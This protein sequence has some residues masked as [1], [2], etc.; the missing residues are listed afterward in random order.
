MKAKAVRVNSVTANTIAKVNT[1]LFFFFI[2]LEVDI[3]RYKKNS[4]LLPI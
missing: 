4:K 2:V 1:G 3:K